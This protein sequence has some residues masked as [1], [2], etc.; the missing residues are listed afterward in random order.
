LEIS[1]GDKK[2]HSKNNSTVVTIV[3]VIKKTMPKKSV[4]QIPLTLMDIIRDK[5]SKLTVNRHQYCGRKYLTFEIKLN[6][7]YYNWN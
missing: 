3:Q 7:T 6:N 1:L 2:N 4:A 5:K